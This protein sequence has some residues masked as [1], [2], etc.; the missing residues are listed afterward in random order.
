MR[1]RLITSFASG[2]LE[3]CVK[4]RSGSLRAAR[5]TSELHGIP[6]GALD[7]CVGGPLPVRGARTKVP[8]PTVDVR[9]P[10]ASSSA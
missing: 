4:R 1:V 10:A 3:N 6:R 5:E 9:K 7:A 2:A 8:R